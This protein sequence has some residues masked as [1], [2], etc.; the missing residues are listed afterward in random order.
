MRR[1]MF[2]KIKF[3]ESLEGF[4][5]YDYDISIQSIVAGYKNYVVYDVLIEH[6]SEGYKDS[7]YYNSLLKIHKKWIDSL[8]LFTDDNQK[9]KTE[10][11]LIETKRLKKFIRRMASTGF[12]LKDIVSNTDYFIQNL[13]SDAITVHINGIKLRTFSVRVLKFVS[14]PFSIKNRR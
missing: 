9:S 11:Q 1:D 14:N 10:I 4:H 8:P 2:L 13:E 12:S 7:R 3:D 6:Y 5:G